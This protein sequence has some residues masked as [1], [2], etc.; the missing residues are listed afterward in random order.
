MKIGYA[1]VST[2]EQ[3]LS[4]QIQLLEKAGCERIFQDKIS[5]VKSER[6]GLDELNNFARE[7]D[8]VMIWKFDRLGRSLIDLINII[9]SFN[10]KNIGVISLTDSIDTTTSHGKLFFHITGAFAEFERN[11]IK[12]RTNAGLALAK[13][14]GRVG[15]RKPAI[16]KEQKLLIESLFNE[17]KTYREI[18]YVM[19]VSLTTLYRYY[20]ATK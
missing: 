12:E 7:G 8:I 6:P 5:G 10:S 3:D 9:N 1:R 15:G 13:S 16:N 4:Y 18:S 11:L 14:Q 2:N 17:G 19:K 20:P